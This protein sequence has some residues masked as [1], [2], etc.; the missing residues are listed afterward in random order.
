MHDVGQFL[1]L[2]LRANKRTYVQIFKISI[3]LERYYFSN[4]NTGN[5]SKIILDRLNRD[6]RLP[7]RQVLIRDVLSVSLNLGFMFYSIRG[8]RSRIA[9]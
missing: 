8:F 9:K 7:R 5:S 4:N 3:T 1:E 6:F 2:Y